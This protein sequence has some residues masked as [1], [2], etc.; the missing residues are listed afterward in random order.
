MK[1]DV[2]LDDGL[3]EEEIAAQFAASKR[4][5][6]HMVHRLREYSPDDIIWGYDVLTE[7][8][9]MGK[10]YRRGVDGPDST[11]DE[12]FA[13]WVEEQ[14]MASAEASGS[15]LAVVW[16]ATITELRSEAQDPMDPGEPPLTYATL[17]DVVV[18]CVERFGV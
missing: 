7:S 13:E 12:T 9:S 17:T 3:D 1:A 6:Q 18:H 4:R 8:G 16:Y 10:T 11:S 14:A 15:C 5:G 2:I